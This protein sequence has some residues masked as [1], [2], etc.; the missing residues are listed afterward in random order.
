V[1]SYPAPVV[2]C[3]LQV[4]K[5]LETA[6]DTILDLQLFHF[7]YAAGEDFTDLTQ[8]GMMAVLLQM[9]LCA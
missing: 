9:L 2:L 5:V 7:K 1:L 4:R 6:P 8:M 3:L